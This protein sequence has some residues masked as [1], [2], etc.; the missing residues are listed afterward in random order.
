MANIVKLTNNEFTKN[1]KKT[2]TKVIL[3]LTLIISI[4]IPTISNFMDNRK[5]ESIAGLGWELKYLYDEIE[6]LKS[7][8]S[9]GSDSSKLEID[10][11]QYQID[12]IESIKDYDKIEYGSYRYDIFENLK[13]IARETRAYELMGK[14]EEIDITLGYLHGDESYYDDIASYS[15]DE[16]NQKLETVRNYEDI[17][18]NDNYNYYIEILKQEDTNQVKYLKEDL[19]NYENELK[20]VNEEDKGKLESDIKLVEEKILLTQGKVDLY[21][22]LLNMNKEFKDN[23][24]EVKTINY[25]IEELSYQSLTPETKEIYEKE[26]KDYYN[27]EYDEYLE[28]HKKE[29]D[30]FI[31]EMEIYYYSIINKIPQPAFIKDAR[32]IVESMISLGVIISTIVV[33]IIGGS[34]IS[35]EISQGTIRLLLIRPVKRAKIIFTKIATTII[36]GQLTFIVFMVPLVIMSGIL[37]GFKDYGINMLEF[38]NNAV[39]EINFFV[40]LLKD[41]LLF[42]LTL[43]FMSLLSIMLSTLIKNTAFSVAGSL[44]LYLASPIITLIVVNSGISYLDQGLISYISYYFIDIMGIGEMLTSMGFEFMIN[45]G[46]IQLIIFSILLYT[47]TNLYFKRIDITN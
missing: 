26:F 39:V 3:I 40:Y 46:S 43:V 32:S 42:I 7:K 4:L 30:S 1:I 14:Y 17:L 45:L 29:L 28:I 41:L 11:L 27:L 18:K 13:E 31:S 34:Q 2:S 38:N 10:F 20:N 8:D 9:Y 25:M 23:S 35:T 16:I 37:Y 5:V 33:I 22:S 47:I 44:I 12:Q 36:I 19:K 6:Y 15:E 24:Y 21:D